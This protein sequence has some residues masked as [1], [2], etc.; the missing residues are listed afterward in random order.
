MT[1]AIAWCRDWVTAAM[2]DPEFWSYRFLAV[3]LLHFDYFL[4][5][6]N[7]QVWISWVKCPRLRVL[8]PRDWDNEWGKAPSSAI[9]YS[10]IP[11]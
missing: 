11:F 3:R 7:L 10:D 4:E 1:N 5:E 2:H 8:H 6:G 9:D